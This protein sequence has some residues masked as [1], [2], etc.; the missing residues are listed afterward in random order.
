MNIQVYALKKNFG[1]Q[2]ALRFFK[3]RG[4]KVTEV[5]LKK[6]RLGARELQVFLKGRPVRTLLDMDNPK[7]K[8]SPILYT[9]SEE[10]QLDILLAHPEFLV[11]PLI[12]D[13]QRAVVGF[14]EETLLSWLSEK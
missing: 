4:I 7:V 5:D 10:K 8:E 11:T 13:G 1:V 2:K 9:G 12:R 14:D 6:H 3:E